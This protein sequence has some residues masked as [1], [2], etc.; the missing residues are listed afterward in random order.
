M[1][2]TLCKN[3][4]HRYL[5]N[6]LNAVAIA[7]SGTMAFGQAPAAP[8]P[9]PNAGV[10]IEPVQGKGG[11]ESQFTNST[12]SDL[13][14]LYGKNKFVLK[15]GKTLSLPIPQQE[16]IDLKIFEKRPD[17]GHLVPRFHGKTTPNAQKRFIPLRGAKPNKQEAQ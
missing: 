8:N 17:D 16:I 3:M 7:I 4:K 5:A 6:I 2:Y 10:L 13:G 9:V 11:P 1:A 14:I 12:D 15:P